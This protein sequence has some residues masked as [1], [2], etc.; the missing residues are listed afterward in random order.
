MGVTTQTGPED[1]RAR[2]L[3]AWLE[4]ALGRRAELAPVAVDA[5]ARRYFRLPH[6]GGTL[7]AM[8]APPP[9]DCA[10][11]VRNAELLRAAGLHA[12]R[13]LGQDLQ[14]GF[15]LLED[16]GERTYLHAFTPDNA[17]GL[18][19]DALSALIR[20][21]ATSRPGVLPPYDRALLARE[22]ELFPRWYLARH[23][24]S[25]LSPGQRGVLEDAFER[26]TA[27]ALAQP[28]VYVHRDYMP[29][30]LMLSEP[31]PGVLDF[32]DAVYG[33]VTYDVIS[34]FRDA[35]VY[36][37]VALVERGLH[38]YWEGA[39]RAGVPVQASFDAFRRDADWMG[40]QRHLKVIGIFA[41]IA[42]RDGKPGYLEDVPRFFDY[43]YAAATPYP[44]FAPLLRLLEEAGMGSDR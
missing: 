15:L 7:I 30:N 8:D 34:L 21:Q 16:L 33:P 9:E 17:W 14:A 19:K 37:P 22:L 5:S 26:L 2:R 39:R 23:L 31:N 38:H 18:L 35:F 20:W 28:R 42:H 11:F 29:R 40:L 27:A 3:Q 13:V 43:M 24:G 6:G 25:A 10:A 12:P 32:Q 4:G 36:W 41:R 1:S 44:E